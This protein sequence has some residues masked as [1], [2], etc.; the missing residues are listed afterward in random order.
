[1]STDEELRKKNTSLVSKLMGDK[2]DLTAER[3]QAITGMAERDETIKSL[4]SEVEHLTSELAETKAK[5]DSP[6]VCFDC[7]T[8]GPPL[9]CPNCGEDRA[10]KQGW[11]KLNWRPGTEIPEGKGRMIV[12]YSSAWLHKLYIH[13]AW[14]FPHD[15]EKWCYA[16]D[17]LG[18]WP[19]P[20]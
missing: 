11:V 13:A 9:I 19:E 5:L 2:A 17:L 20:N 18:E 12:A 7:G 16:S 8:C 3:D 4:R 14:D 6:F 1:M 15:A 10:E